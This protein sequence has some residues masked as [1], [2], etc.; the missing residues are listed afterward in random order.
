MTYKITAWFNLDL[1]EKKAQLA[2]LLGDKVRKPLHLDW[3]G[4]YCV[5]MEQTENEDPRVA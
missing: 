2:I 5:V 4:R 1:V 3:L